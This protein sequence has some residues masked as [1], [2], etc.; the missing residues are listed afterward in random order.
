MRRLATLRRLA[1][2]GALALLLLF[3]QAQAAI[4]PIEHFAERFPA[5]SDAGVVE[6]VAAADCL[7]CS[8]LAGG[9]HAVASAT[10]SAAIP[11]APIAF[12]LPRAALVRAGRA[13]WFESRAPPSFA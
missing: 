12:A 13:A 3:L 4:H 10:S 2:A 1:N 6:P 8:L 9:T 7:Q 11:P 5:S